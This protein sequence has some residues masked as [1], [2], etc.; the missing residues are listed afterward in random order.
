MQS[1]STILGA[2][3]FHSRLP[4]VHC[5]MCTPNT[6]TH[7]TGTRFILYTEYHISLWVRSTSTSTDDFTVEDVLEYLYYSRRAFP[8]LSSWKGTDFSPRICIVWYSSTP[9]C[10]DS[11]VVCRYA[12]YGH[13]YPVYAIDIAY[14][15]VKS[16]WN[17]IQAVL[18]VGGW[19]VLA[20]TIFVSLSMYIQFIRMS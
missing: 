19:Q 7:A 12:W 20:W 4:C 6:R 3:W 5:A 17:G 8:L 14:R 10:F 1:T 11:T 18:V 13:Y 15:A 9:V 2:Y 16:G